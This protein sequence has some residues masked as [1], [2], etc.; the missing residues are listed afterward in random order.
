MH[1]LAGEEVLVLHSEVIEATGGSHGLRDLNLFLSIIERPKMAFGG[2]ELYPDVHTKAAAYLESLAKFHVFVD[3]NKRTSWLVAAR[4]L[5]LN[6]YETTA[7]N[8]EVEIFVLR[9]IKER[10]DI[11]SIAAWLKKHTKRRRK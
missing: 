2:E 11:L 5:F 8:H 7:T 9:V 1:Y 10:L 4:F 3:G 6:G